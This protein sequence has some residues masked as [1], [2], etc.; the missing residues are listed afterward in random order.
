MQVLASIATRL[1]ATL[2]MFIS[3]VLNTVCLQDVLT[4]ALVLKTIF[5]P[6]VILKASITIHVLKRSN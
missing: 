6:L 1:G 3:H 4:I 2:P 5:M